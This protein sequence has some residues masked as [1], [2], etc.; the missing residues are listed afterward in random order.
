MPGTQQHLVLD[1]STFTAPV[2]KTTN[3]FNTIAKFWTEGLNSRTKIYTDLEK[4][5]PKTEFFQTPRSRLPPPQSTIKKT[6]WN[7]TWLGGTLRPPRKKV[8][9][10]TSVSALRSP[11]NF[12]VV[13][14]K[15]ISSLEEILGHSP[16][17]HMDIIFN[18]SEY[19]EV[20]LW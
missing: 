11:S 6:H 9:K 5:L 16:S 18:W 8:G 19:V 14:G 10:N 17:L 4:Q 15:K 13:I 2:H 3:R 7:R 1:G 20:L 12:R